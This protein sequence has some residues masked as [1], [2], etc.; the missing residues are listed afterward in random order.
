MEIGVGLTLACVRNE[1]FFQTQ[2]LR[3]L[4][5][6]TFPPHENEAAPAA[7]PSQHEA[8]LFSSLSSIHL[9]VLSVGGKLAVQRQ[10]WIFIFSVKT[11]FL[12]QL[13]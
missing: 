8:Y 12:W 10:L 2:K 3:S 7:S 6:Q 4:S 11:F 5:K 13:Q 1:I 9:I